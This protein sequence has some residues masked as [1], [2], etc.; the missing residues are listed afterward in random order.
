MQHSIIDNRESYN[1]Q[2]I[3]DNDVKWHRQHITT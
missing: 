1:E 2:E 3:N